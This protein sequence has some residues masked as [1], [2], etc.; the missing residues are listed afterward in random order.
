VAGTST[1]RVEST[2]AGARW[3]VAPVGELDGGTYPVLLEVFERAMTAL[4][5]PDLRQPAAGGPDVRP[6]GI[7]LDLSALS[8]IDSAGLRAIIQ[9][10]RTARQRELDLLVTPPPAP[11]TELLELTGVADRLTLAGHQDEAPRFRPFVERVEVE[12][13]AELTAP[14]R[15]RAEVRQAATG[16][17]D[18]ATL[19]AAI[20]LTSELVA[21]AVIHPPSPDG[22]R[23]RLR[24]TCYEDGIRCEISDRGPGFDPASLGPRDPDAGGRGLLLVDVLSSRWG[25]AR[26]DDFCVWFELDAPDTDARRPGP[27]GSARSASGLA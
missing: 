21:N 14:S 23:V 3:E 25:T 6:R 1:F 19:D 18:E 27:R 5:D 9:L 7:H 11:L 15:A 2:E 16:L 13:P 17:L 8:F 20:L 10:E 22:E 24:I 26:P 12:L 4:E